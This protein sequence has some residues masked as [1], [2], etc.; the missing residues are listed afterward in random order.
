MERP[1][2]WQAEFEV[3]S[4]NNDQN[5]GGVNVVYGGTEDGGLTFQVQPEFITQ[6]SPRWQITVRPTYNRSIDTQQYVD[7]IDATDTNAPLYLF[8]QIDRST[9]SAEVR[10]NYTFK[11]DL[12]LDFYGEPF[13]ASGY[14]DRIGQLA[15]ARGRLLLPVDAS[16][17]DPERLHFNVRSFRSNLVL[18]WEWRPGSTFYA[19]W[20]QDREREGLPIRSATAGDLFRAFAT[21]GDHVFAIKTSFWISP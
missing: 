9:W 20:Q 10:L 6:P 12:T 15:E 11:P 21:P 14:Y 2:S 3:E 16:V 18:R 8:G 1:R 7:T 4:N 13:A 17:A 19:V 5:R